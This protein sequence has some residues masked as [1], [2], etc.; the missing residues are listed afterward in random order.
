[1]KKQAAV[2][3]QGLGTDL[4]SPCFNPSGTFH[5]LRQASGNIQT[6]DSVGNAK[7]VIST[8]GQPSSAVFSPD[9]VLY[10]ADFA[11]AGILA[12]TQDGNQEMVVSIYEDKPLKGPNGIALVDGDIFF[13]DS[14][15]FGET[16]IHSPTGSLFVISNSPS[17]Q[18]LRPISLNNLAYPA[19]LVV[20]KDKKFMY[21]NY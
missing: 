12:Y 6:I 21:A 18:I 3:V 15:A 16:G 10:I 7:T 1:M 9:G 14:G 5:V 4:L 8:G 13:T 19:G 17:G 11:H 20:T 2:F